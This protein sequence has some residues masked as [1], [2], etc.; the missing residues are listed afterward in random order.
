[1]PCFLAA[2]RLSSG[3][4]E[5]LALC[6]GSVRRWQDGQGD[7]LRPLGRFSRPVDIRSFPVRI[8]SIFRRPAALIGILALGTSIGVSCLGILRAELVQPAKIQPAK[9]CHESTPCRG[10][11]DCR[12]DW[13]G[14]NW[15]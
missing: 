9:A 12:R 5:H 13:V 7:T 10:R 6:G 4:I 8:Q 3:F 14:L 15:R 1:M 2:P 11:L